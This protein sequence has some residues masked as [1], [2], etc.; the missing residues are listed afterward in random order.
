MNI[1]SSMED[2]PNPPF[3]YFPDAKFSDFPYGPGGGPGQGFHD[4]FPGQQPHFPPGGGEFIPSSQPFHMALIKPYPR[5]SPRESNRNQS[6]L[7]NNSK[8]LQGWAKLF[9]M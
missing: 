1:S 9:T 2:G 6:N 3:S 5:F 7:N 8:V 4:F